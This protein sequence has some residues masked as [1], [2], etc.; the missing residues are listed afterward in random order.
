MHLIMQEERE[1]HDEYHDE[2]EED[3]NHDVQQSELNVEY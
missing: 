1:E 2:Y 3:Q